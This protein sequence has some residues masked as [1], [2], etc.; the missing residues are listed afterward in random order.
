MRRP[1][2]DRPNRIHSTISVNVGGIWSRPFIQRGTERERHTQFRPRRISI[3]MATIFNMLS[4]K[5]FSFSS[6]SFDSF[7]LFVFALHW[8]DSSFYSLDYYLFWVM[9]TQLSFTSRR[10][11]QKQRFQW[12]EVLDL[13]FFFFRYEH[14]ETRPCDIHQTVRHLSIQNESIVVMRQYTVFCMYPRIYSI[15]HSLTY[16]YVRNAV[17]TVH[18]V[19]PIID[20][21]W[22]I[23]D[24]I[25]ISNGMI[26]RT[27]NQNANEESKYVVSLLLLYSVDFKWFY[28][29]KTLGQFPWLTHSEWISTDFEPKLSFY[30]RHKICRNQ[31]LC[32]F[33]ETITQF[34]F[35]F[36]CH[37]N[38]WPHNYKKRN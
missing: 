3:S 16:V 17:R 22:L 35:H 23:V 33:S 7:F 29:W 9:P 11:H 31:E 32:K 19:R 30:F 12:V 34:S 1:A 8:C 25:C 13:N 20:G 21:I 26:W 36:F 14:R 27:F 4:S 15:I 10:S 6:F 18:N 28:N 38:V 5:F 24:A 2:R 37:H